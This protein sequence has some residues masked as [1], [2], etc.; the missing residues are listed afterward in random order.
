MPCS[1]CINPTQFLHAC[2]HCARCS[3]LR[4]VQLYKNKHMRYFHVFWVSSIQIGCSMHV[5]YVECMNDSQGQNQTRFL[6]RS[7]SL[8]LSLSLSISLSLSLDLDLDLD[9]DLSLSISLSRSLSLDLSQSLSLDL[10][11]SLSISQNCDT[12]GFKWCIMLI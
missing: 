12:V 9:L 4:R 8:S 10:S 7:L 1:K 3:K 6:A 5:V 2:K 11:I